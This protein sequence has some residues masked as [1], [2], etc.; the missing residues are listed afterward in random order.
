M[1]AAKG[2]RSA[3][4]SASLSVAKK[5]SAVPGSKNPLK[6]FGLGNGGA[7][8]SVLDGYVT[9]AIGDAD[10]EEFPGEDRTILAAE[11]S[12]QVVSVAGTTW[13]KRYVALSE[14][15]V[16]FGKTGSLQ[17]LD[18]IPLVDIK[19]IHAKNSMSSKQDSQAELFGN[20]DDSD[21][22]DAF[23]FAIQ[24]IPDGYNSGRP[25]VLSTTSE[26]EGR[27]WISSITQ[28]I[29]LERHRC[30]NPWH[31]ST[32]YLRRLAHYATRL[33]MLRISLRDS[34]LSRLSSCPV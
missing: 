7:K 27:N 12:R 1:V 24:V 6:L 26:A 17:L 30:P 32:A 31:Q 23:I 8:Q 4:T 18:R 14:M 5:D 28:V 15:D 10:R 22:E 20:E 21:D 13:Q 25:T 19:S 9:G 11:L 3:S 16:C 33:V 34:S 29:G 2:A